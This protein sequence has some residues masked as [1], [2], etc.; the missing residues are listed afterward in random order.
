VA[1]RF[2]ID[3]NVIVRFLTKDPPDMA[4]Q[5]AKLMERAEKG[6]LILIVAPLVLAE[7]VWVLKSFYRHPLVEI[8]KVLLLFIS[9][10]GIETL[11]R[12][13]IIHAIELTRDQNV[14]FADAYLALLAARQNEQVCTFDQTDFQR[15]PVKWVLP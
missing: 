3:A 4:K 6:E 15:L 1:E 9:A 10:P 13:L 7:V 5:A 8:C 2:W 14:D 11:D 12:D